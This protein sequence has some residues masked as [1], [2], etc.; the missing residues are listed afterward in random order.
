MVLRFPWHDTASRPLLLTASLVLLAG[1][2]QVVFE[3]G[4]DAI[5][6]STASAG[7][8]TGDGPTSASGAGGAASSGD[9]TSVSTATAGGE[10]PGAGGGGGR[11][12]SPIPS[13]TQLAW[14]GGP[15]VRDLHQEAIAPGPLLVEPLREDGALH[16]VDD[17]IAIL[18]TYTE[19]D[20]ELL[21][22]NVRVASLF[23]PW[24]EASGDVDPEGVFL[25]LDYVVEWSSSTERPTPL[26]LGRGGLGAAPMERSS[27]TR[28]HERV[29]GEG[30]MLPPDARDIVAL[31]WSERGFFAYAHG[32]PAAPRV[33]LAV[34]VAGATASPTSVAPCAD[35][36]VVVDLEPLG[37]G[38]LVA[39][40]TSRL[41]GR[42]DPGGAPTSVS[43]THVDDHGVTLTEEVLEIGTPIVGLELH[44]AGGGAWL[45]IQ[46]EGVAAVVLARVDAAGAATLV[47]EVPLAIDRHVTLSTRGDDLVLLDSGAATASDPTVRIRTFTADLTPIAVTPP[48]PGEAIAPEARPA[49]H[50]RA[51]A[52]AILATTFHRIEDER[53]A[54]VAL[55]AVCVDDVEVR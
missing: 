27:G 24:S 39:A 1:C 32:A 2:A 21:T 41:A 34:P 26:A 47:G 6:T 4:S 7:T 17:T 51:D 55:R 28:L 11:D 42:C 13:C 31:A 37:D 22:R 18:T 10:D 45:A 33:D 50:V 20:D 8:A 12:V 14:L 49:L 44:R 40:S 52:G 43:L 54:L 53:Y 36:P 38:L 23:F 35:R 48:P 9:T 15:V 30:A 29:G 5:D 46:A 16:G 25:G 19:R 3:P